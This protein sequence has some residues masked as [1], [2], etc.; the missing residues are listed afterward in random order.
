MSLSDVLKGAFGN[1]VGQ[2]EQAALPDIMK[3]VLGTEG[4]QAILAKLQDAGF[5]KQVASWIDQ[6][7]SNLP[8]SVD[9]LRAALGDEH[10]QQLAKSLGIP[11]DTILAGLA[12]KLP[13]ITNA[14]GPAVDPSAAP[15]AGAPDPKA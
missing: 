7:K 1:A 6:N 3:S 14:A 13:E 5:D 11:I 4:V 2:A 12:D 8:I 15:G 9:Q 10:I